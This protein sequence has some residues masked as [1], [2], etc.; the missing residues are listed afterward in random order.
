MSLTGG[1]ELVQVACTACL[2]TRHQ[3]ANHTTSH[4]SGSLGS[5]LAE[6]D[7]QTDKALKQSQHPSRCVGYLISAKQV[8]TTLLHFGSATGH[9]EGYKIEFNTASFI[10]L[11]TPSEVIASRKILQRQP[12]SQIR[13]LKF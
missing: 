3:L 7:R 2:R 6:V 9:E 12:T 13:I 1:E 11:Y 8:S 4:S 10:T 5:G